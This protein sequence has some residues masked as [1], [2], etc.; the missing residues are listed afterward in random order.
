MPPKIIDNCLTDDYAKSAKLKKA[1]D[2]KAFYNGLSDKLGDL[3][4]VDKFS[5]GGPASGVSVES[6]DDKT[7]PV[8]YET[9]FSLADKGEGDKEYDIKW[10]AQKEISSFSKATLTFT[11]ECRP[12]KDVEID[13]KKLQDGKWEVKLNLEFKNTYGKDK[14]KGSFLD[15]RLG[16]LFDW[17]DIYY[18]FLYAK[19]VEQDLDDFSADCE[20]IWNYIKNTMS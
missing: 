2:F 15:K 16:W 1:I 20:D 5:P 17:V 9:F 14:I 10:E 7:R 3:D 12:F 13:K 8:A 11:L 4:F 19:Q 18:N 6:K